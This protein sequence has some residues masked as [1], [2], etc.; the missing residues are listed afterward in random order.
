MSK[1]P[2][3]IRRH[4]TRP[5]FEVRVTFRDPV[6]MSSKRVSAYAKSLAEAKQKL[7]ELEDRSA[8]NHAP[9]D[10]KMMLQDWAQVWVDEVLASKGLAQ[11]TQDLYVSVLRS[12]LL[13]SPL[14]RTPLS[15]LTPFAIEKHMQF[16]GLSKSSSL[17]RVFFA[18]ISHLLRD[19]VRAKRI[20]ANP[21]SEVSRPKASKSEARFLSESEMEL[22]TKAL[23][24]DRYGNVFTFILQTGLRRGEVLGLSWDDVDF[25]N[26]RIQVRASLD[27]KK[28]RGPTKTQRSRR[29]LDLN[30]RAFAILSSQR[31]GQL[32]QR[33]KLGALYQEQ[34]WKPVFTTPLGQP[35]CP[36]A[37]LRR[38]QDTAN[39]IGLS[40]ADNKASIGIHTLRHYVATKLIGSGVDLLV[41]S[42]ILGH[43]SIQTTVD[44]YGHVEDES[45]RA[46]LAKLA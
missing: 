9:S 20:S 10:S 33:I 7:R 30:D 5:G 34:A 22:L 24:Q 37:L 27:A 40:A 44:I 23:M 41:T 12:H 26:R 16:L 6:T 13:N 25:E 11:T 4:T 46:A 45:R 38:L 15:Q 1:L 2:S 32:E 3:G 31:L 36:R 14:G 28:R 18:L 35:I 42:R 8:K 17:Q 39:R 29:T 19:A 43:D 21:L